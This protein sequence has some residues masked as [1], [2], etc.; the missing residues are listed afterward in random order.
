MRRWVR[1]EE[2][3]GRCGLKN[4]TRG[5]SLSICSCSRCLLWV[6][7]QV[8]SQ[9][10]PRT[11]SSHSSICNSRRIIRAATYYNSSLSPLPSAIRTLGPFRKKGRRY[12]RASDN[13]RRTLPAGSG[14]WTRRIYL[15]RRFHEFVS[16]FLSIDSHLTYLACLL[17]PQLHRSRSRAHFA[18]P[19]SASLPSC[20]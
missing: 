3:D 9:S 2:C 14:C 5:T 12:Y 17:A 1:V 8:P 19:Q 16:P 15:S 20:L 13:R 7:S 4:A 18:L 6:F 11:L 10:S